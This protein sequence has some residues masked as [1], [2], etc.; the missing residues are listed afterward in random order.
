MRKWE[1][2]KLRR[3]EAEK[4]GGIGMQ[5]WERIEI[6]SGKSVFLQEGLAFGVRCLLIL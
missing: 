4:V 6:G 3:L 5:M 1:K 2:Q